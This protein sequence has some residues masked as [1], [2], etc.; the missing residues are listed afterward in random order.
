MTQF[1]TQDIK[2]ETSS[3]EDPDGGKKKT[4][5]V[6]IGTEDVIAIFA[7]LVAVIVVVAMIAGYL[8]LNK[9]TYGLAGLSAAGATI[10]KIAGA[11][12]RKAAKK[13]K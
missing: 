13:G 3:E 5:K 7:G 2:I 4:T 9:Y 6:S 12:K 10:A 1:E 11:K 8:P